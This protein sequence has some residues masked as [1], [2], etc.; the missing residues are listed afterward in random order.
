MPRNIQDAVLRA[1]TALPAA[2]AN[3]NSDS[4][5][6]EQPTADTINEGFSVQVVIPALPALV[7][8]KKVTITFQDSADGEAFVAIPELAAFVVTAGAEGGAAASRTVRLPATARRYIRIN[9]AVEAAGGN[10]T[11]VS[12][13]L[14]LLF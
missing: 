3:N 1:V 12:T 5:D 14:Q 11:A 13:T 7:D 2:G 9:Q 6:L 10:N 8:T 4:I